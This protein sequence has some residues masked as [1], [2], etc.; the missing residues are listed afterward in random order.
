ME[1]YCFLSRYYYFR[2][3]KLN[4]VNCAHPDSSSLFPTVKAWPMSWDHFSDV[5]DRVGLHDFVFGGVLAQPG[6][7]KAA[8]VGAVADDDS[9]AVE[10]V[11]E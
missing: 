11:Y 9:D 2:K 10:E 5:H 7:G 3:K 8:V 4:T 6:D 1:W